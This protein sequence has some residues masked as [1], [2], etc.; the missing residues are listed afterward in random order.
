MTKEKDG[1][2]MAAL[3]KLPRPMVNSKGINVFVRDE[4]RSETGQ[5][6]I[7]S[8]KHFLKVRDIEAI[9]SIIKKPL[10]YKK[11]P[12]R[13][14]SMVYIGKRRGRNKAPFMKIVTNQRKDEAEEIITVYP[15][16]RNR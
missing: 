14:R 8:K 1:N 16:K 9:P 4:A 11:D 2:I 10:C 5:E 7:A 12:K 6:H 13:K 15:I 3:L